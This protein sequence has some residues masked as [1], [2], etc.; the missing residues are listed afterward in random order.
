M[1]I[2]ILIPI[3]NDWNSVKLLIKNIDIAIKD[4]N[5]DFSVIIVNDASTQE[6]PDNILSFRN[7]KSIKIINMISNRGHG[8]C[9]AAGLK[10]IYEKEDF[11][12]V[13]PMDGD[14]EDRPDEIVQFV[15]KIIK[16]PNISVV[17]KR[18]K[19]SENNIFKFCYEVHKIITYIFTGKLIRFGHFTCIPK[20]VVKKMIN[21]KATWN[22][23]SASLVKITKIRDSI[24]SIR[25]KRYFDL[26]KMSF[27]NLITHSLSIISV[28]KTNVIIR[29]LGFIILYSLIIQNNFSIITSFPI[30]L[31]IIF[32]ILILKLSQRENMQEY[33][34]CLENISDIDVVKN[35]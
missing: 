3:F 25:G 22:C 21:E 11:D 5:A 14:G 8:R 15:E 28:F 20:S 4:I 2:K 13:L 18:V 34:K 7:L 26:S 35:D 27:Y 30:V 31:I 19:R 29:S 16:N 12:Y 24:P 9:N 23:Y 6:K 33:D 1:K 10:Y 32:N 17:G